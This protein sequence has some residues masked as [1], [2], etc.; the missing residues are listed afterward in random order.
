VPEAT[1]AQLTEWENEFIHTH[2]DNFNIGG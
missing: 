2:L 1:Q